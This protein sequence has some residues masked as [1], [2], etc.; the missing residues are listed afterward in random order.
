M[1]PYDWGA[2]KKLYAPRPDSTMTLQKRIRS[3]TIPKSN[4]STI[5][6]AR[7]KEVDDLYMVLLRS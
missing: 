1:P 2:P 5:D 6:N 4:V 7:M 3:L